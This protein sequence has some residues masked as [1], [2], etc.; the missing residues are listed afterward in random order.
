MNLTT[1]EAD[2]ASQ[3]FFRHFG[4][5]GV[6]DVGPAG[7]IIGGMLDRLASTKTGAR[8]PRKDSSWPQRMP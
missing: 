5:P 4:E 1:V 8:D 2:V 7:V 3:S 6:F